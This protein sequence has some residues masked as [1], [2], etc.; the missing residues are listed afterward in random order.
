MLLRRWGPQLVLDSLPGVL[1]GDYI[2]SSVVMLRDAGN[3]YKSNMVYLMYARPGDLLWNCIQ[4]K[5]V[6]AASLLYRD[7]F[8]AVDRLT[9]L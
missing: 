1:S 5:I 9:D 4:V 8:Y 3:W 7:R 2:T 6:C